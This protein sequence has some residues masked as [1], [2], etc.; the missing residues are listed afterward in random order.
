M[1]VPMVAGALAI[2]RQ[3]FRQGVRREILPEGSVHSCPSLDFGPPHTL[4]RPTS[5]TSGLMAD[6]D[7]RKSHF[8]SPL[9][10]SWR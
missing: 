7:S 4:G 6:M 1:A 5:K 8:E 3:Y 10:S 2:I 9:A